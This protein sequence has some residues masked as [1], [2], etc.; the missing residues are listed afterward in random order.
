M[1]NQRSLS[2]KNRVARRGRAMYAKRIRPK[3]RGKEGR[4]VAL[5]VYT[6]SMKLPTMCLGPPVVCWRDARM[7]R[8][9]SKSR[10]PTLALMRQGI[11]GGH[12]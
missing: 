8:F 3:S 5:D 10:F 6:E 1:V 9:G 12:G 7:R 2:T 4:V 11:R